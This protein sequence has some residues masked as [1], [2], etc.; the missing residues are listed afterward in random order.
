MTVHTETCAYLY[1]VSAL[2][3]LS[4]KRIAHHLIGS[5]LHCAGDLNITTL[6]LPDISESNLAQ[7]ERTLLACAL[8]EGHDLVG[9]VGSKSTE[10]F[11]GD[12][13]RK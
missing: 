6:S 11:G 7:P 1:A 10:L 2:E 8:D 12:I 5:L 3:A 13:W 4:Q 9:Y